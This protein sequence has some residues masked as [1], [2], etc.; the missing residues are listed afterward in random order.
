MSDKTAAGK[1]RIY[2]LDILRIL[3]TFGILFYHFQQVFDYTPEGTW[4]NVLNFHT[5][6]FNWSYLVE[7]FFVLSGFLA[8]S[9]VKKLCDDSL[10]FSKF[11]GKKYARLLPAIIMPCAFYTIIC[12]IFR[13]SFGNGEWFFD[14]VVDIPATLSAMLG[15]QFWGVFGGNYIN[16][17]LWYV[18]V[19]LFCYI[20]MG[21]IVKL[22]RKLGLSYV[23]G[24][25]AMI[26]LGI[27][28]WNY[29]VEIPFFNM[30]L[31]RGYYAFF[32][33]LLLGKVKSDDREQKTDRISTLVFC[34]I[35]FALSMSFVLLRHQW[36]EDY[37]KY[38]YTFIAYPSLIIAFLNPLVQ[39]LFH[40]K[41]WG[42]IGKV[43]YDVYVW[44]VVVYFLAAFIDK[45]AGLSVSLNSVGGMLIWVAVTWVVGVV[46]YLFVD[47]ALEGLFKKVKGLFA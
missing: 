18:D 17:P 1:E 29:E 38:I 28:L 31:A 8:F 35:V 4:K 19:L 33:G 23:Y 42:S 45:K 37:D 46:S 5:S 34:L 14:T 40:C 27:V 9:D 22:S 21:I 3:A 7:F 25:I 12:Y 41:F 36:F 16:Y 44:Q 15:I 43:T 13:S 2:S 30:S 20:V 26:F 32:F 10:S 6:T 39:K 47:K 24:F 11:V